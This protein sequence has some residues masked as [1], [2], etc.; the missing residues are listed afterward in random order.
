MSTYFGVEMAPPMGFQPISLR[1]MT[2]KN[3]NTGVTTGVEKIV[4]RIF[5]YSGWTAASIAVLRLTRLE[6]EYSIF[7]NIRSR[8]GPIRSER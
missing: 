6:T 4:V 2:A 1:I 3:R 8:G 5:V 7:R